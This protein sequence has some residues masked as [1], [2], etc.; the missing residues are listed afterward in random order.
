M[1]DLKL[2]ITV[3][4][5]VFVAELGDKTQLS[6]MLYASSASNGKWAVFLGSAL[7]LVVSSAVGVFAG[8]LIGSRISPKLLGRIAGAGFVALGVW[9]VLK[10]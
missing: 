7:A 9:T 6:T 1:I 10:S 2:L 5:T 3:F 4:A 8:A